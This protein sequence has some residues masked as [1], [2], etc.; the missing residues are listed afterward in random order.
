[1][2][3]IWARRAWVAGKMAENVRIGVDDSGRITSVTSGVTVNDDDVATP[4]V[5]F[6][7]AVN[8]H[9]HAFHRLL[10]GRTHGGGGSFWTWRELMYEEAGR[11]TPESYERV[12]TELYR[13]MVATGWTSVAEFHYVHHAPDGS[14]YQEPH[15][16]EL[17]VAR[18]ARAAGIRLTLL[19]TCYLSSG[20]GSPPLPEQ[21]RFSDGS[22]AAW[23]ARLDSLRAAI[24]EQFH[25]DEVQVGAAIHSVRA[26][27]VADLEVIAKQLD[28]AIPL[29]I[30]LSEQP[31]EN[32]ACLEATGTTPTRLL[33]DLGLL[34]PGLAAVHA[35]HL[36]EEDIA[37]LGGSGCTIVMC[38]TT[39]ADLGDGVGPARA[40]ANAGAVISLGTDQHAVVDP[41]LETRALEH[42][43]RLAS[44]E[45]GRFTPAE[46]IAAMTGGA[47]ST[48]RDV[49]E[50]RVGALGDF[51]AVDPDSFRTR[52]SAPEQLVLSA[53]AADVTAVFVGGKRV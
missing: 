10:R 34:R 22:A 30:H 36:T 51:F 9:S 24:T 33:A 52:G 5:L 46:L 50:I 43:E 13:E 7:G 15:A 40:L 21:T 44:G 8:A 39:E 42:G 53:T 12:A 25:P 3:T 47:A 31:A 2:S 41:L 20:F 29:H 38:P 27:P 6:P 23:L 18:A 11:L 4:G 28:P 35:T 19:D 49:G 45:R 26:V 16:M 14:P 37:L 1:M 32:Q 17:A 48:G